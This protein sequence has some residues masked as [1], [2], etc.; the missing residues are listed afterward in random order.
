ML[1]ISISYSYMNGGV[2]RVTIL[3]GHLHGVSNHLHTPRVLYF[4]V[5][6]VEEVMYLQLH[7][8]VG[9]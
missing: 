4:L 2:A 7:L 3:N 6:V 1:F 8:S 9:L 5:V